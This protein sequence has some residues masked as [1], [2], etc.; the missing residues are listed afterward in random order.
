LIPNNLTRPDGASL[1]EDKEH[2]LSFA[3]KLYSRPVDR[4]KHESNE[5]SSNLRD[6]FKTTENEVNPKLK[7]QQQRFTKTAFNNLKG[8]LRIHLEF[9][10]VSGGTPQSCVDGEDI[11]VYI[12]DANMDTFF[13]ESIEQDSQNMNILKK[14]LKH[15]WGTK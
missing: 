13:D 12:D 14:M 11:L 6:C 5:G 4:N 1:L 15:I 3:I 9:P 7:D 2:G 8:I 10:K